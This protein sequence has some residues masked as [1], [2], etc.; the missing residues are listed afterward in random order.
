MKVG[1]IVVFP[2]ENRGSIIWRITGVFYGALGCEDVVALQ[3]VNLKPGCA[4]GEIVKEML[5]PLALVE[6][7]VFSRGEPRQ[8]LQSESDT[9]RWRP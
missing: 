4:F 1:D 6:G 7:H 9:R 5:V 8:K 2:S 3:S